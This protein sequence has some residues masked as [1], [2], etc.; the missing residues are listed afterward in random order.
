MPDL[1]NL[2]TAAGRALGKLAWRRFSATILPVVGTALSDAF[3]EACQSVDSQLTTGFGDTLSSLL[4]GHDDELSQIVELLI[5]A[6]LSGR[7]DV[8]VE[9]LGGEVA[10]SDYDEVSGTNTAAFLRT[11][12]P[13]IHRQV[14]RRASGASAPLSAWYTH[15]QNNAILSLLRSASTMAI[16]AATSRS[17]A[18]SALVVK[19]WLLPVSRIPWFYG[20]EDVIAF[21]ENP[22]TGLLAGMPTS[23]SG[24]GGLGKTQAAVEFAHRHRDEFSAIFLVVADSETRVR[25]GLASIATPLQLGRVDSLEDDLVRR[26]L[27]WLEMSRHWLLI[28]D[29]IDDISYLSRYLPRSQQGRLLLT[30]RVDCGQLASFGRC[31]RLQPLATSDSTDFLLARSLLSQEATET[32]LRSL[33]ELALL[34][35]GLPLALEQMG[36]YLA[37]S[38]LVHGQ[39]TTWKHFRNA[40]LHSSMSRQLELAIIR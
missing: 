20:R 15:V 28:Y 12:T 26:V 1:L 24:L 39:R 4:V 30:S 10:L 29:G 5:A 8:G 19:P 37:E 33:A 21:L 18:S 14:E 25:A 27:E 13:E 22:P 9:I 23:L 40:D 11:L 2:G 38:S 32:D 31:L 35:S 7:P 3:T 17:D 16:D 6:D 36:A 34:A